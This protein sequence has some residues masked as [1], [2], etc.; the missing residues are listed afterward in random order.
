MS[1]K[2]SLYP[3]AFSYRCFNG[4]I[5][6]AGER[7]SPLSR[8]PPVGLSSPIVTHRSLWG[9]ELQCAPARRRNPLQG[10]KQWIH[11]QTSIL[12]YFRRHHC[13][14]GG[15]WLLKLACL[16]RISIFSDYFLLA[17]KFLSMDIL[18]LIFPVD[19]K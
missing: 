12:K 19:F 1:I 14:K 7:L 2:E 13:L 18:N 11:K 9:V 3:A 8:G 15:A 16:M 10:G 4:S 5:Q 6:T 17:I